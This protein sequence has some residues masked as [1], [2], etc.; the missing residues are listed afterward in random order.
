MSDHQLGA[1]LDGL[2]E[3]EVERRLNLVDHDR[4]VP[5]TF[6]EM[7]DG[8]RYHIDSGNRFIRVDVGAVAGRVA[9]VVPDTRGR[10]AAAPGARRGR[11]G[12]W[13]T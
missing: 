3:A 11:C 13:L 1:E 4:F 5:G 10:G 2:P 6:W 9:P 12:P 8:R 7:A